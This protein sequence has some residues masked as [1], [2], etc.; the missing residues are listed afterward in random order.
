ME[1]PVRNTQPVYCHP[2]ALSHQP[3][4]FGATDAA[5]ADGHTQQEL[6]KT[7]EV[8]VNRILREQKLKLGKMKRDNASLRTR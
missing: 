1:L 4:S 8:Q 7:L 2:L 6:T 5:D 3:G